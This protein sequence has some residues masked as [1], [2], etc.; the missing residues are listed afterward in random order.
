MKWASS[1]VYTDTFSMQTLY[2]SGYNLKPLLVG[3]EGCISAEGI[4][5]NLWNI[6]NRLAIFKFWSD[7][8]G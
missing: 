6:L 7:V 5:Y 8:F 3:S 4:D 1:K 2:V